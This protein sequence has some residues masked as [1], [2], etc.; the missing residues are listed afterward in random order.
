MPGALFEAALA[1][2][3]EDVVADYRVGRDEA[4]TLVAPALGKDPKL[5]KALAKAADLPALERTRAF[6]DARKKARNDVYYALRQ[7]KRS[8]GPSLEALADA[9]RSAGSPAAFEAAVEAA[10]EAHSSTRE[11]RPS[12]ATLD[13]ALA[14][15]L[16]GAR[17][18]LDVGCGVYPLMFPW[19]EHALER[20]VALDRDAASVAALEAFAAAR[21]EP[22]LEARR[23]RLEDGWS[24]V[25]EDFDVA[26]LLKIVPVV[27]RQAPA[28]LETLARAPARRLIVSGS[29]V[30]LA[31]KASIEARERALLLRFA[32]EHGFAVRGAPAVLEEEL[33]FVLERPLRAALEAELE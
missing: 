32:D 6:K 21:P 27:A 2:I 4:R 31:K 19:A 5:K 13:A 24:D 11:R 20:Y 3:V 12:R 18:V 25:D 15:W 33:V 26:L 29:R 1:A 9:I 7:Y 10:L 17:G 22:R 23:W 28:L 14:P 8:S 16:E 30:A